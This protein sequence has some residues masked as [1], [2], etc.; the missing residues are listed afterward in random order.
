MDASYITHIVAPEDAGLP[1]KTLLRQRMGLSTNLLR[2]LKQTPG[3]ILLE[4]CPVTVRAEVQPGQVLA[5]LRQPESGKESRVAAQSG[6][7][8]IV[9]EDADL[10]V[11]NKPAGMP[12]HPS[13][14]HDSNTLANFVMG[15]YQS[16]G[17]DLL[18]H[19]INRL[20]RGTSGLICI[21]KT[22]I[23]A[24]RLGVALQ[25]RE[26]RRTYQAVVAGGPGMPAAGTVNLPIGRKPGVGIAR[27]VRADGERAVTHFRV[28]ERHAHAILLELRLETG[29]THQIRVHCS[30][31][32]HPVLG[33]FMY[34][35][36][37]DWLDGQALHA[38]RLE[39]AHPITGAD[40][41]FEAPAPWYFAALLEGKHPM[42]PPVAEK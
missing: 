27:E 37:Y 38:C 14:G 39:F 10:L 13:P 3:G 22:Q 2:R 7:L 28:L 18:F 1:V 19:P 21:A 41:C 24:Q 42:Q 20:D 31:L 4:G 12:V 40:L 30:Y 34:G 23:A 32:G 25:K 5:V 36:E 6:T 35:E 16:R 11:I 15:Y 8:D 26:I 33:D 29:R 17:L 9:Y